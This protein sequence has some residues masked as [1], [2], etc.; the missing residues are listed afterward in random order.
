[1]PD[2]DTTG[3]A[4]GPGS[5]SSVYQWRADMFRPDLVHLANLTN[6][7][8]TAGGRRFVFAVDTRTVDVDRPESKQTSRCPDCQLWAEKARS[9]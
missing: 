8:H 5:A 9:S 3:G 7:L 4:G 1:M 6:K 2:S